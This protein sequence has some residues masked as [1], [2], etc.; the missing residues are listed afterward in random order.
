MK[1][2][3]SIHDP[4]KD[5]VERTCRPSRSLA[6]LHGSELRVPRQ[7]SVE[8]A[9]ER[10][11]SPFEM[12][13]RVLTVE[14]DRNGRLFSTGRCR[15]SAAGFDQ[16]VDEVCGRRFRVPPRVYEADEIGQ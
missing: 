3:A 15:K 13:P 1:K 11:A 9:Q 5:A 16:T 8:R 6:H 10:P 7:F 4:G 12:L 2:L 14:D